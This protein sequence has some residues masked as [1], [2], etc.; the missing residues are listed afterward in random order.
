MPSGMTTMAAVATANHVIAR[1]EVV[2]MVGM[3]IEVMDARTALPLPTEGVARAL[4]TVELEVLYTTGMMLPRMVGA[5]A[6][7]TVAVGGEDSKTFWNQ[8]LV[9]HMPHPD[10][11]LPLLLSTTEY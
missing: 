10:Y 11:D 4:T 5:G 8:V 7:S 2:V 1:E 9:R 3:M 6:P